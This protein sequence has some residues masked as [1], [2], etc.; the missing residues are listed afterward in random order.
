[1]LC[2]CIDRIVP[3]LKHAPIPRVLLGPWSTSSRNRLTLVMF[4]VGPNGRKRKRKRSQ[5]RPLG[6]LVKPGEHP[7]G[8]A[9]PGMVVTR[10]GGSTDFF[11]FCT[12]SGSAS[13]GAICGGEGGRQTGRVGTPWHSLC[14]SSK[15]FLQ[16]LATQTSGDQT[17]LAPQCGTTPCC[18]PCSWQAVRKAG[19]ARCSQAPWQDG[20]WRESKSDF[21]QN[22]RGTYHTGRPGMHQ[23]VVSNMANES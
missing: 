21:G 9:G 16:H 15:G 6:A 23:P 7:T 13:H 22:Q 8:V 1:M 20:H 12:D 14:V 18:S 10:A 2:E 19:I 4:H 11:F 17:P 5:L 3:T